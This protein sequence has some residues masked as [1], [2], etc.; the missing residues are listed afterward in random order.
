MLARA[1]AILLKQI[2]KDK[3]ETVASSCPGEG[4]ATAHWVEKLFLI[5]CAQHEITELLGACKIIFVAE[6]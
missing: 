3:V 4:I 5:S 2:L 1:S 6:A